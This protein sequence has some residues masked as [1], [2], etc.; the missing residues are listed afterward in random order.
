MIKKYKDPELME[1][2]INLQSHVLEQSDRLR[3]LE[4]EN[5]KLKTSLT[6]KDTLT[7]KNGVYF[8]ETGD[9]QDGPFC[10]RCWDV[11]RNL[12]RLNVFEN[13]CAMC[14]ECKNDFDYRLRPDSGPY[15]LDD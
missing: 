11:E 4:K 2:V 12:V 9:S 7:I 15:N 14:P 3:A 1:Q 10:T 6:V 5:E 8:T 13:G